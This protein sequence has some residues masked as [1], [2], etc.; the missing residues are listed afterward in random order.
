[1]DDGG[2]SQSTVKAAYINATCFSYIERL[3]I[4]NA[5]LRVFKL[6]INIHKAG[7]NNQYNF[8]IPAKSY[9]K[10]YTIVCPI[11]LRVPSMIYKLSYVN[12]Y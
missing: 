5:F 1:M 12:K 10:F 8:Y 6:K 7:K 9:D 2:K 4:Q 11:I 3:Q